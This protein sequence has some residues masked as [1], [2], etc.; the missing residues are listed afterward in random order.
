MEVE[1]GTKD[2]AIP[3]E[4]RALLVTSEPDRLQRAAEAFGEA[5]RKEYHVTDPE[6]QVAVGPAVTETLPMDRTSTEKVQ[7]L[8]TSLPNGVQAMSRNW[9]A[10]SRPP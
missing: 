4:A 1:G 9:R 5:V 10:W 7:C 6:L 2:N 8:L 3:R